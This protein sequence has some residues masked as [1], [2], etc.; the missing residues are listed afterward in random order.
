MPLLMM[1]GTG[2]LVV[3]EAGHRM[4]AHASPHTLTTMKT[5][6]NGFHNLLAEPALK[7]QVVSDTAIWMRQVA[8]AEVGHHIQV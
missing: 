8:A 5:Y 7:A 4:L 3:T 6:P 2:D 1:W